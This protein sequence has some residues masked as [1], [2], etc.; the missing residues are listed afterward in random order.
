MSPVPRL[1]NTA[2]RIITMAM[3]PPSTAR[4]PVIAA[5]GWNSANASTRAAAS[6]RVF[7]LL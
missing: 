4:E 1:I 6:A 2:T 3:E 5:A 7:I